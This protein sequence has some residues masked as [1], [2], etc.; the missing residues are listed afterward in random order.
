MMTGI[1]E[2]QKYESALKLERAAWTAL[3]T[4]ER[5]DPRYQQLLSDWQS[6]ADAVNAVADRLAK[7]PKL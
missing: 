6:A 2:Q 7:F 4:V 3:F 5:S 1:T